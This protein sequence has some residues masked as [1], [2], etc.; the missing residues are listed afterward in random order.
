MADAVVVHHAMGLLLRSCRALYREPGSEVDVWRFCFTLCT[1]SLRVH[2][3]L[4]VGDPAAMRAVCSTLGALTTLTWEGRPRL[5]E[6]VGELTGSHV[7][8]GI[9]GIVSACAESCVE[10]RAEWQECA[11]N[12]YEFLRNVACDAFY[13]PALMRFAATAIALAT[14]V[15][16]RAPDSMVA[17]CLGFV[18]N[19][20][21]TQ[22]HCAI[23]AAPLIEAVTEVLRPSSGRGY[24]CCLMAVVCL[25]NLVFGRW[26]ASALEIL[27]PEVVSAARRHFRVVDMVVEAANLAIN[28]NAVRGP[29]L[30]SSLQRVLDVLT[31]AQGHVA[32]RAVMPCAVELANVVVPLTCAVSAV[33][34]HRAALAA[35]NASVVVMAALKALSSVPQGRQRQAHSDPVFQGLNHLQVMQAA[36]LLEPQFSSCRDAQ[37]VADTLA[38]ACL[39]DTC[40]TMW[41]V[42]AALLVVVVD[43]LPVLSTALQAV[44]RIVQRPHR[45]L[46]PPVLLHTFGT[47]EGC[48]VQRLLVRQVGSGARLFVGFRWFPLVPVGSEACNWVARLHGACC[49][50]PSTHGGPWCGRPGAPLWRGACSVCPGNAAECAPPQ[51]VIVL[52]QICRVGGRCTGSLLVRPG[53]V[54]DTPRGLGT[55][56]RKRVLDPGSV[57][58]CRMGRHTQSQEEEIWINQPPPKNYEYSRQNV[59]PKT[60]RAAGPHVQQGR[61]DQRSAHKPFGQGWPGRKVTGPVPMRQHPP[62]RTLRRRQKRWSRSLRQRLSAWAPITPVERRSGDKRPGGPKAPRKFWSPTCCR[63]TRKS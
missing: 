28:L 14:C 16:V 61:A 44:G 54:P 8:A 56:G 32:P 53:L 25:R 35:C 43:D 49:R 23:L 45:P 3:P 22:A 4:M 21:A 31:L 19:Q 12:A 57:D 17:A 24:E 46:F 7:V 39:C 37:L 29:R 38:S 58:V 42:V 18:R 26:D 1:S 41:R 48:F 63:C 62:P 51:N 36:G 50:K 2:G 6:G 59:A 5:F 11:T 33:S 30:R 52:Q 34:D 13:R 9:V 15:P 10:P 47:M 27:W 55:H 40:F 20:V 60:C